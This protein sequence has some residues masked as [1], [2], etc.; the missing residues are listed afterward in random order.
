[1]TLK[2]IGGG[3]WC[4]PYPAR[5]LTDAE[6]NRYGKDALLATGLYMDESAKPKPAGKPAQAKD[7][8]A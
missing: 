7:G 8:E 4:P 3:A 1:M 2:Y 5:D 6:V